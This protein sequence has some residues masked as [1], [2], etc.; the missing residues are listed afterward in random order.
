MLVSFRDRNLDRPIQS[1]DL[2]DI[3]GYVVPIV[4]FHYIVGEKY[5]MTLAKQ[6]KLDMLYTTKLFRKL[7]ELKPELELL[8]N[9]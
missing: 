8:L 2:M 7:S 3:M 6:A 1:N 9:T 5:F 4:Y